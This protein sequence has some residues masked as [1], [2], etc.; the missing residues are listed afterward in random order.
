MLRRF[1]PLCFLLV[2]L[3][4]I[5]ALISL[6]ARYRVEARNRRVALVLDDAQV[7]A[8][9]AS[10]GV[11]AAEALRQLKEAGATG[12]ALT[13]ETLADLQTDGSLEV[14]L[15]RTPNGREYRVL[16]SDIRLAARVSD[17]VPRFVRSATEARPEGDCVVL[18]GP[19]GGSVYLPGRWEDV[20]LAPTGLDSDAITAVR[21]AGLE[22]VARLNNPV[23]LTEESLRWSLRRAKES[24][25]RILIFA[26]EEVLGFTKLIPQVAAAFREFDLVYGTVE[27]GKQRG[28]DRLSNLLQ[29]RLVRVH[30][31][32]AAEMP[33]LTPKEAVERYVRAAVERNIRLCYVRLPATVTPNTFA[34]NVS[35]VGHL[36]KGME[37]ESLG[38]KGTDPFPRI[39]PE[40]GLG[41]WMFAL[42]GLG[43]GGGAALLFAGIVP[44][45]KPKQALLAV[46]FG[47]GAAGLIATGWE[48]GP[49]LAALAAAV[50]FP[51]LAFVL[52]PQPVG[53]F[54][55]H[56]HAAVRSRDQA[57]VPAVAEFAALSAVTLVGALLVAGLL[58]EL[59]YLVKVRGFIGIKIATVLPIFLL[60]AIYLTG[61]SGEYPSW[62][63]EREAIAVRLREFFS[64]PLRVWHTVAVVVGLVALVLLVARSGNDSGVGVSDLELRFRALLDRVLGVRP[65]TKEFLLGHPALML[66]LGMAALPKWRKWA[67]PVM[68]LGVIGQVGMLNSFCHLH[69]P[70]KLTALRT[71]HGLWMGG[72]L[73]LV[74]LCL[75][76]WVT[77][78]LPSAQERL[79]I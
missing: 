56:G 49:E 15:I 23:G 46:L 65:R 12:V 52:L 72:L 62:K 55:E 33:R 30:S 74:A 27:F 35:Y 4:L 41:R 69:S 77:R 58:S 47:A 24:G 6:A 13:E 18:P 2:L 44:V 9:A 22:P 63:A 45:P 68:L 50:I 10:T 54:E 36:R 37:K 34:D 71:F 66:A 79:K 16:T 53:A 31:I 19:G 48:R 29:E 39:W 70:L 32:A 75:F 25:I 26:G 61:A 51:T 78:R 42:I 73:G 21:A 28:D 40:G 14:R 59:P 7:R 8:L 5:G 43:V 1:H 67:L 76:L 17:Y 64:E 20:R 38:I 57:V 11:S 60:G 3:G